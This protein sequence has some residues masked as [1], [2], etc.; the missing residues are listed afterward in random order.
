[1]SEIL[2]SKAFIQ[3]WKQKRHVKLQTY[4]ILT[5]FSKIYEKQIYGRIYHLADS[6]I[7]V[8]EQYGFRIN[9][10]TVKATRK[11]LNAIFNALRN[12]KIVGGILCDLHKAF[13]L[14]TKY[15]LLNWNFMVLLVSSLI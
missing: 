7:L 10:S 5:P 1:M 4:I 12:N 11:L 15:C 6:N 3:K 14:I 8:D 13:V 2:Y 9:S